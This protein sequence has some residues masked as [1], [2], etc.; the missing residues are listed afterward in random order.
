MLLLYNHREAAHH[1][2][3]DHLDWLTLIALRHCFIIARSLQCGVMHHPF[4]LFGIS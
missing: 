3:T 1:I 4:H 2:V